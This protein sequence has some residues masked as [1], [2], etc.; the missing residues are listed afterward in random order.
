MTDAQLTLTDAFLLLLVDTDGTFV[1]GKDHVDAGL[2]AA[3]LLDLVAAG[4]LVLDPSG[5]PGK[6]VLHA[7]TAP[8]DP[9]DAELVRRVDGKKFGSAI[10]KLAGPSMFRSVA[11]SLRDRH[12]GRLVDAGVLDHTK[13][14]LLGV[15][16]ADRYPVRDA[17][18]LAA[19]RAPLESALAHGAAPDERTGLLVSLLNAVHALPKAFPQLDKG[20][21]KRRGKE[22][23]RG[24]WAG[25][26]VRKALDNIAAMGATVTI[27]AASTASS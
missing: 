9:D 18:A 7:G 5:K 24:E 10:Q 21:V 15:I 19:V 26:Q 25:E 17:A 22:I 12:L 23:S 20:E 1:V 14:R 16:P 4:H 3:V 13:R 8:A 27:I 2:A 6:Q 11:A